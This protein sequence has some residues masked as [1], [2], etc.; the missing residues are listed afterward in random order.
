MSLCHGR[1]VFPN[2][3]FPR[4]TSELRAAFQTVDFGD[5]PEA[6]VGDLA[7]A[8]GWWGDMGTHLI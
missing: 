6:G 2:S 5:L 8:C 7:L 4:P 3:P 1:S